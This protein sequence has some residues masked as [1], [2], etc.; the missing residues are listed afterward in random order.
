MEFNLFDQ[1]GYTTVPV[2]EG[3]AE[4]SRTYEQSVRD[5]MDLRLLERFNSVDWAAVPSV[6]DFACGTGRI[7]VWLKKHGVQRVDGVDFTPEMLDIAKSKNVYDNLFSADVTST[8]LPA[9]SYALAIQ[10]L[11]DEHLAT[12]E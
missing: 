12:L 1:R 2:R 7:G 4:W 5:E 10:V 9:A 8:G 3:Y 6:L 11:A